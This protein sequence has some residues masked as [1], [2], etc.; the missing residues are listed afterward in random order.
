VRQSFRRGGRLVSLA[1]HAVPRRI[2]N[3]E[4]VAL[5]RVRI[6]DEHVRRALIVSFK[7]DDRATP[8]D[9][10]DVISQ[11]QGKCAVRES[12]SSGCPLA[13]SSESRIFREASPQS[14]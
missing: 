11:D 10:T 9:F 5:E 3:A 7:W 12:D 6:V 1:L 8:M 13:A 4:S 14:P 2:R